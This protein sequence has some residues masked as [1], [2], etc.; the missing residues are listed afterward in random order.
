MREGD[1]PF[2]AKYG[3]STNIRANEILI[4]GEIQFNSRSS[5]KE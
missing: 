3:K 1:I 2:K 4:P 5:A